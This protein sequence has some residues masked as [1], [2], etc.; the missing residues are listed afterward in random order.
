MAP[1]QSDDTVLVSGDGEVPLAVGIPQAEEQGAPGSQCQ[2]NRVTRMSTY[3]G[4]VDPNRAPR[5]SETC[6]AGQ[7][8]LMMTRCLGQEAGQM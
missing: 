5:K 1:V 8:C 6:S 4:L 3:F 2:E 7:A